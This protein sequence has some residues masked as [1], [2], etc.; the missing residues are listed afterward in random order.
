MKKKKFRITSVPGF[1]TAG[2][3]CGIKRNK[4]RDLTLIVS[5]TP[6][7]AASVFTLNPVQAA[8]VILSR[9]A[10]RTSRVFR[11]ILV[12]S[13]NAN[14]CTGPQGLK[15]CRNTIR[16]LAKKMKISAKEVLVASTGI[17]GVPMP[18]EKIESAM[19]ELVGQLSP[20]NWKHAAEGIMT[21]DLVHKSESVAYTRGGR[22][23]TIAGITKG[24]GMIHPDMATMLGFLVT[25]AEIPAR[26]LQKALKEAVD[27]TFNS[28]TVD[29]ETSTNDTVFILAN[30][31]AGNAAI[32]SGSP[33][34]KEFVKHLTEVCKSLAFQIIEDGE[35]ATKF[36]TVRVQGAKSKKAAHTVA[37]SVATS[38]LVKTALF[39]AD[40]NWGRILA[41]AGYAGVPFNPNKTEIRINELL[42]FKDGTPAHGANQALLQKKMR[43]KNIFITIDLHSGKHMHEVYTCDF[44]YDY[45]R[46]NAEY[47]T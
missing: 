45:V 1:Q 31:H 41:S 43:K 26:V 21:T 5:D 24:S 20:H 17:I 14:A 25:D 35:G 32:Q 44:S 29:R 18:A 19:P 40:P 16:W 23:I 4:Q 34:Y 2:I 30:G 42:V 8:P 38:P 47:T 39:G 28:I 7:V 37:N 12:N 13:G 27:P 33:D 3:A 46:I 10:M 11:A 6:A 36:A 15:D 9:K 22:T